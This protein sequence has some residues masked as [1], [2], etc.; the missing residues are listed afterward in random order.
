MLAQSRDFYLS[1][2]DEF[3][4]LVW[5]SDD[6]GEIGY[7]NRSW[8]EFAGRT[9]EEERK[10]GW[11]AEIHPDERP[12]CLQRY[13]EAF[14]RR[15]PFEIEYRQRRADGEYR[16]ILN[17]GRPYRN[18]DG[19]FA[20]FV[21]SCADITPRR[22][23]EEETRAANAE[24]EAFSYTVSHDLRA[25]LRSMAGICDILIENYAAGG[26]I[27]PSW[28]EYVR[29]ISESAGNM[30]RLILDLLNFSR[31]AREK[32]LLEPVDLNAAVADSARDLEPSWSLTIARPLGGPV[33]GNRV[34]LSQVFSNLFS[35]A[36]KFVTEGVAPRV[37]VRTE[38][39]EAGWVRV[40]V[41]DNGIGIA[42]EYQERI[43]K[44][45]ERLN[46][47]GRY[48]GS[49]IGLAIVRRAVTRMGGRVGVESAEGS[50][51][52]FWLE[53]PTAPPG[54]AGAAAPEDATPPAR[55]SSRP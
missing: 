43:W 25:P 24:L 49:G 7:F 6:R 36:V 51:S 47:S 34:L 19:A 27:D 41:E 38:E 39:R 20:G 16:W 3:P 23:S 33:I 2:F 29:R 30:D 17:H 15:E 22:Q 55:K 10:R 53:L 28:Q 1:L 5:R 12:R 42:P 18:L 9:L 8:L 4:T 11:A 48:P 54:P 14:A 37:T 44:A 50:G 40:W 31:L 26:R 52:R 35:N 46:D 32:L 21:G 45:F 13:A